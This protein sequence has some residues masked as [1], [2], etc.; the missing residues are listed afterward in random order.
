MYLKQF[1]LNKKLA[2]ISGMLGVVV[3]KVSPDF[4]FDLE[5]IKEG[6]FW[7]LAV[8]I[9]WSLIRFYMQGEKGIERSQKELTV[10][11]VYLFIFLLGYLVGWGV[12]KL[13]LLI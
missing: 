5:F 1:K 2:L 12:Q 3:A 4:E 11:T 6:M 10:G 8:G 7:G 13:I 9:F